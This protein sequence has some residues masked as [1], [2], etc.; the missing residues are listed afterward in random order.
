MFI[1]S[2]VNE[3]CCNVSKSGSHCKSKPLYK[4]RATL[5]LLLCDNCTLNDILI[6]AVHLAV[7]RATYF[8]ASHST[9]YCF[10]Q[11]ASTLQRAAG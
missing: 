6:F 10:I 1:Y 11:H 3:V 8:L 7:L 5:L 2:T 9:R 4:Q